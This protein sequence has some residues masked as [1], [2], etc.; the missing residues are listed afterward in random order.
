MRIVHFIY[1]PG[2]A[3]IRKT[4]V[5]LQGTKRSAAVKMLER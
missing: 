5:P 1:I 2:I 4:I 3:S